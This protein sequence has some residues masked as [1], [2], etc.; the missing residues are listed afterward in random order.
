MMNPLTTVD[1][2]RELI[3]CLR[4][5]G[6]D[7][8]AHGGQNNSSAGPNPQSERSSAAAANPQPL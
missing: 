5:F 8:L 4:C 7:L 6:R 1:D 2:L 3:K